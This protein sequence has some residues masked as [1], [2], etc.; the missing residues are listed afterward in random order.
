MDVILN[1][2]NLNY[3]TIFQ[4]LTLSLEKKKIITIAGSNNSGKTT[5]CR[6]LDRKI[7]DSF[8]INLMGKDID[9][10]S[11]EKYNHLLQVVYPKEYHFQETTPREEIETVETLKEKKEFIINEL[12][13]LKILEREII[14]CSMTERIWLQIMMA[15]LKS[16]EIVVID[17]L[18]YYFDPIDLQTFYDFIKKC[19][20]FFHNSFI[21]T[22]TSLE[23]A[24]SSDVLYIIQKGEFI[25]HGEPL[26]VLQRDNVINKAG[27]SVPFM[28]DLSV[29]LRD[30]ELI[31]D[32]ELDQE[33]LIEALWN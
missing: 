2:N 10:Y 25:L 14:K 32:I 5:L 20:K 6:I 1:I 16:S 4:N 19:T 31:K 29:K 11:L 33:R 12:K 7:Q 13:A 18:D 27:L 21:V 30:Y 23:M 8:N 26:T 17:N 9:E 22:A 28:I 15:I 24:T 3:Q